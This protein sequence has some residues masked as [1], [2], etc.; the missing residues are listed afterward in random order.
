VVGDV[1]GE[2]LTHDGQTDETNVGLHKR[3]QCEPPSAGMA[4]KKRVGFA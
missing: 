1:E 4:N 3:S 2:V